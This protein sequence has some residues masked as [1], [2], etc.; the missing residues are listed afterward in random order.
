MRNIGAVIVLIAAVF[1]LGAALFNYLLMPRL[2]R[3]GATVP[4]PAVEGL[5]LEQARDACGK[6]RLQLVEDDR[7]HSGALPAGFVV[8]QVPAAG[9]PVKPGRTV[10]V[11]V[12]LGQ[13]RVVVPDLRGM[14]ERQAELALVNAQ[15][16][17]GQSAT[18]RSGSTG[19][20][21]RAT[22]PPAGTEAGVGDSVHVLVATG[23]ATEEYLMPSLVGQ[24]IEDVQALLEARGFRVGRITYR[25]ASADPGIV[26]EHDPARGALVHRGEEIDLVVAAP[27]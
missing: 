24:T 14:S 17:L 10:R 20:A 3:H 22:R 12:S 11:T 4:V 8:A 21:V 25:G 13:A 15:L 27:E 16:V 2:V 6:L 19:R 7:R 23:D 1:A 5:S 9:S 18:V 26:L